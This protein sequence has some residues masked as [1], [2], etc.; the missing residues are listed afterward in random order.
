[1][2]IERETERNTKSNG[3]HCDEIYKKSE[4]HKELIQ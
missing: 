1:M 4:I 3:S 2:C